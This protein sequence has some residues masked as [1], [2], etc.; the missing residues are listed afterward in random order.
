MNQDLF[1]FGQPTRRGDIIIAIKFNYGQAPKGRL[2]K[3]YEN[4]PPTL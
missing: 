1:A 3:E 4:I 2:S